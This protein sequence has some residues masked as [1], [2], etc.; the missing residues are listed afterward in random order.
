MKISCLFVCVCICAHAK[1]RGEGREESMNTKISER[2]LV[3]KC[4]N[5]PK[6]ELSFKDSN[7]FIGDN[8][9]CLVD[10]SPY[11]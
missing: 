9:T 4:P 5:Q 3:V 2:D 8:L 11:T 1:E 7:K 6:L 10:Y